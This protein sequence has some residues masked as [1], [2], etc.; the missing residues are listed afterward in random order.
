M[1][2]IKKQFLALF[3]YNEMHFTLLHFT[4]CDITVAARGGFLLIGAAKLEVWMVK[5]ANWSLLLHNTRTCL[6]ILIV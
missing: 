2:F 3:L 1:F 4:V 5:T 6:Y